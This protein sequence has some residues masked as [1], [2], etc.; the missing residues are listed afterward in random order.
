M[1]RAARGGQAAGDEGY[2]GEHQAGQQAAR[3]AA[4]VGVVVDAVNDHADA[5]GDRGEENRAAEEVAEF[6]RVQFVAGKPQVA[7]EGAVDAEDGARGAGGDGFFA[8][9]V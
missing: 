4:A 1:A 8:L 7:D 2:G 6:A 3:Q 9:G 5:D